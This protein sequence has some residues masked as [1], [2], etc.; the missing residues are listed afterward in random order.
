MSFIPERGWARAY[1]APPAPG[2][3]PGHLTLVCATEPLDELGGFHLQERVR[4]LYQNSRCII[5]DLQHV[6]AMDSGGVRAL[7]GIAQELEAR[8]KELRLVIGP[9]SRVERA[10]DLLH[11]LARFRVFPRLKDAWT[12]CRAGSEPVQ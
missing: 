6:P 4:P 10:L 3:G 11:L 8:N 9:G 2:D 5:L 12:G 1:P 7:L